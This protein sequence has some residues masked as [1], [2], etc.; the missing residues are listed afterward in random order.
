MKS[1]RRCWENALLAIFSTP[2]DN[3][4][5]K[6]KKYAVNGEYFLIKSDARKKENNTKNALKSVRAVGSPPERY[7]GIASSQ[8]HRGPKKTPVR[9]PQGPISDG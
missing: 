5:D 3:R 6:R 1:G 8:N 9:L 4:L 2:T 7:E